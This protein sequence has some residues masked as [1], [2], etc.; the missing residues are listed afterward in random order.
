MEDWMSSQQT[1]EALKEAALMFE[2]G[3]TNTW[4][5]NRRFRPVTAYS[6]GY[7]AGSYHP[8][9]V[10]ARMNRQIDETIKMRLVILLFQ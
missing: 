4:D 9:E 7:A 8:R 2:S 6:T 1:P 3:F 10:I 5:F